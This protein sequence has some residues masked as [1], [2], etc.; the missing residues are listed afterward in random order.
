V[1]IGET[2]STYQTAVHT[3]HRDERSSH[4]QDGFADEHVESAYESLTNKQKHVTTLYYGQDY[5]DHEIASRL[6]VS[7]QA[8]VKTRHAALKKMKNYLVKEG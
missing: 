2:L 7:Q 5:H 6:Q 1:C 8:V 4:F 3:S